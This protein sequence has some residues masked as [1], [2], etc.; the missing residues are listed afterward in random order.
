MRRTTLLLL[1]MAF[2]A[3]A[4]QAGD[5]M[6]PADNSAVNER[7]R[8]SH[9]LTPEDQSQ[10]SADVKLAADVRSAVVDHEGLSVNGQN[11][12]I[13]TRN[14]QVTLR[15][16]VKDAAERALI[17]KTVRSASGTATVDNQLEVQ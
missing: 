15:G 10:S 16:P 3:T 12:K 8:S 17:E 13:I 6:K 4:A 7:D 14:N 2:T 1:G 11:I 5:K 9:S